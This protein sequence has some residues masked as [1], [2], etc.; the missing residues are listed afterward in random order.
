M[1]LQTGVRSVAPPGTTVRSVAPPAPDV[2]GLARAD[3]ARRKKSVVSAYILWGIVGGHYAYLGKGRLQAFFFLTLGGFGFWWLADA[4]RIPAL[5]AEAN[6]ELLGKIEARYSALL[7][8]GFRTP[9]GPSLAGSSGSATHPAPRPSTSV[10]S[11][12]D[13]GATNA[14]RRES[15]SAAAAGDAGPRPPT[16]S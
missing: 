14:L 1:Q 10:A 7:A 16:S 15:S 9:Q 13:V 4:V 2:H 11:H 12:H 6:E 3:Y 5:V 8:T